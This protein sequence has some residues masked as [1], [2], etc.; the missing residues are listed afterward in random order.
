MEQG[1]RVQARGGFHPSQLVKGVLVVPETSAREVKATPRE[2]KATRPL[3][4]ISFAPFGS[5]PD[6]S[7]RFGPRS[8]YKDGGGWVVVWYCQPLGSFLGVW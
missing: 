3:W 7:V 6:S 2:V 5:R 8:R 1:S 4:L